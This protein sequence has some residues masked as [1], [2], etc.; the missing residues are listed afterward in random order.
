VE[1][2]LLGSFHSEC[3]CI[4]AI[5]HETEEMSK[6]MVLSDHLYLPASKSVGIYCLV[7]A[8]LYIVVFQVLTGVEIVK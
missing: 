7:K 3:T 8:A 2:D 4:L 6:G 5:S 1:N